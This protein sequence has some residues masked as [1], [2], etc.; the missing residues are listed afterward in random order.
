[1]SALERLVA[2]ASQKVTGSAVATIFAARNTQP[3]AWKVFQPQTYLSVLELFMVSFTLCALAE[4]VVVAYWR[5]LLHG[6][7]VGDM[8]DA[9]EATSL[10]P[11]LKGLGKWQ[12][13][14]A[15]VATVFSAVS[16]AR[17]P[18]FQHALVLGNGRYDVSF[19]FMA[20]GMVA[21][22]G[23]AAAIVP[24]FYGYWELGRNV[25]LNPLEIARAYG[26]PLFD[27]VDGN[28]GARGIEIE[29]GH[30]TVRYGA[31]ERNSEEKILRIEDIG[32]VNVRMPLEGEV[33]G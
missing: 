31:V 28:M 30:L 9:W 16:L 5:R 19:V 10:W 25:S 32:R 2:N 22:F 3:E 11:A 33:F 26:A 6:A 8:C 15:G 17:G 29:R 23:V 13:N 18:L 24:L 4:G 12:R 27:G 20:L 7:P 1:M 14:D 21:S